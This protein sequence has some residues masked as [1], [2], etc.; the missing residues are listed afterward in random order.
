MGQHPFRGG[1]DETAWSTDRALFSSV[2]HSSRNISQSPQLKLCT[3]DPSAEAQSSL[4]QLLW[5]AFGILDINVGIPSIPVM[6]GT[7][8]VK[9][10]DWAYYTFFPVRVSIPIAMSTLFDLPFAW[11]VI[12]SAEFDGNRLNATDVYAASQK[13]PILDMRLSVV[14]PIVSVSLS[15]R[16][17][18]FNDSPVRAAL[19]DGL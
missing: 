1:Y 3:F 19:F 12:F 14:F 9:T 7:T 2:V 11:R 17:T 8:V 13:Y 6:L 15:F 5:G 16:K 18:V 4:Y 10:N